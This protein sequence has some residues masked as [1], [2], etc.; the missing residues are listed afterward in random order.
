MIAFQQ[1]GP[2]RARF[3]EMPGCNDDPII[4]RYRPQPLIESP[5]GILAKP[6]A[7]SRVIVAAVPEFMNMRRV[8]Y[9]AGGNGS[10][11]VGS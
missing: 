4:V 7:V 5:M 3:Q 2:V 6:D 8:N 11:A 10:Q 9:T 1:L